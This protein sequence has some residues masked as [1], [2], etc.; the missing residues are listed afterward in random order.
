M[1]VLA[2]VREA[3]CT[4]KGRRDMCSVASQLGLDGAVWENAV[5]FCTRERSD[6]RGAM[7]R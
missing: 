2:V 6:L 7:L 3:L 1:R 4:P 5:E